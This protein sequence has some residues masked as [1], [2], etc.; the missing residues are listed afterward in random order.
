MRFDASG[1]QLR[2]ATPRKISL[3]VQRTE[4][5]SRRSHPSRQVIWR[6]IS[7]AA[8]MTG[9]V[10]ASSRVV[11][12]VA[13]GGVSKSRIVSFLDHIISSLQTRR[14][15]RR[16]RVA[17][18]FQ[19]RGA[20]LSPCAGTPLLKRP[21]GTRGAASM[22][23]TRC[24]KEPHAQRSW[25]LQRS[26]PAQSEDLRTEVWLAESLRRR[27][28]RPTPRSH[29]LLDE[30]RV[31]RIGPNLAPCAPPRLGTRRA[32]VRTRRYLWSR[33]EDPPHTVAVFNH[34]RHEAHLPHGSSECGIP[35]ID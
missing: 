12:A 3:P 24:P 1:A 25:H 7:T 9:A 13:A 28:A 17:R 29:W 23:V 11:S 34:L 26:L 18:L 31:F 19:D 27:A 10:T 35:V 4:R 8:W 16:E 20:G 21:V 22:Q 33:L 6:E 32:R 5:S 2:P 14:T 30:N 15:T